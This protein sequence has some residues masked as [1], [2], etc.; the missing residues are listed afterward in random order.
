MVAKGV[1]KSAMLKLAFPGLT[2]VPLLQP[3]DVAKLTEPI[4]DLL[5]KQADQRQDLV[6][7]RGETAGETYEPRKHENGASCSSTDDTYT[8]FT[9][10]VK[11]LML[12]IRSKQKELQA[13]ATRNIMFRHPIYA[14]ELLWFLDALARCGIDSLSGL[15]PKLAI[16]VKTRIV[17]VKEQLTG[18]NDLPSI[19]RRLVRPRAHLA[20]LVPYMDS[21]MVDKVLETCAPCNA[22]ALLEA[23]VKTHLTNSMSSTSSAT[24]ETYN[25]RTAPPVASRPEP[26]TTAPRSVETARKRDDHDATHA[27][28]SA[29]GEHRI[30]ITPSAGYGTLRR[31][32]H[33]TERV[34][35][36]NKDFQFEKGGVLV[37][38]SSARFVASGSR[39]INVENCYGEVGEVYGNLQFVPLQQALEKV[40][41]YEAYGRLN[42]ASP[43]AVKEE[44]TGS[45]GGTALR[46]GIKRP[47]EEADD[48]LEQLERNLTKLCGLKI[49][50]K[51]SSVVNDYAAIVTSLSLH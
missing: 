12:G 21:A 10:E 22:A 32:R 9:T 5:A 14:R 46:H 15:D 33:G 49:R 37:Q 40:R 29:I 39:N 1:P 42:G 2:D 30:L 17:L 3:T 18:D 45:N 41:S 28:Y 31:D 20:A 13:Y 36:G 16:A 6:R 27:I 44:D 4:L 7:R 47:R 34:E 24:S 43:R 8:C 50:S 48:L 51:G 35:A 38:S 25:G 26:A 23:F 11:M 19:L